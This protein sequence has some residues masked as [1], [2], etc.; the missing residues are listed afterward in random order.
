MGPIGKL[1]HLPG[2]CDCEPPFGLR[3]DTEGLGWL[4]LSA[5]LVWPGPRT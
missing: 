1:F 3:R 5:H 4:A 2:S